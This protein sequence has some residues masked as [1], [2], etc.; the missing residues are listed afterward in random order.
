MIIS[1]TVE[2]S[3]FEKG[4]ISDLIFYFSYRDLFLGILSWNL[5]MHY[6][7]FK[8]GQGNLLFYFYTMMKK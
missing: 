5:R 6:T 7:L 3:G 8:N 1:D 4:W 2:P